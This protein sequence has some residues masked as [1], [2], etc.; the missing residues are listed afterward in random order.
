MLEYYADVVW[1]MPGKPGTNENNTHIFV[2]NTT[3]WYMLPHKLKFY[4]VIAKRL[5][6]DVENFEYVVY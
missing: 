2:H 1:F 4:H 3:I 6:Y 5:L